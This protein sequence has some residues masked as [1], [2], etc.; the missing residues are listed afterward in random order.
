MIGSWPLE[1]PKSGTRLEDALAIII[2][3]WYTYHHQYHLQYDYLY[4]GLRPK[5]RWGKWVKRNVSKYQDAVKKYFGYSNE[6]AKSAIKVLTKEQLEEILEWFDTSE[7][8][9]T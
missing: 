6:K 1:V 2:W 7:G 8:G 5:K 4:H 9:K 3:Y